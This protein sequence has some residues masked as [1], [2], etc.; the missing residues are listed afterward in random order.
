MLWNRSQVK[1]FCR[2]HSL[3]LTWLNKRRWAR[4]SLWTRRSVNTFSRCWNRQRAQMKA[5][6][7]RISGVSSRTSSTLILSFPLE[8]P[9]TNQRK[10]HLK[11][12]R[13][14]K[15]KRG[16]TSMKQPIPKS[17]FHSNPTLRIW[18]M[19]LCTR[20]IR[21]TLCRYKKRNLTDKETG[22]ISF[23]SLYVVVANHSLD[24]IE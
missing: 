16:Q 7:F 21:L 19:T 14:P 17:Q 11:R 13:L 23:V 18:K 10:S 12:R 15:S 5:K 9:L 24:I 2:S 6:K 8:Q 4:S 1:D 22:L 3:I 20:R